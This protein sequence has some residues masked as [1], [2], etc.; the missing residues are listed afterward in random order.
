MWRAG[1]VQRREDSPE[2]A[3]TGCARTVGPC[4]VQAGGC[5][6]CRDR[7]L[8][9]TGAVRVGPYAPTIAGL[10]RAYKYAGREEAGR[11][12]GPRAHAMRWGACG[13]QGLMRL[14]RLAVA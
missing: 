3:G 13:H 5:G 6:A 11:L 4:G 8:R 10:V 14:Y 2:L 9:I 1:G 7:T 12:L